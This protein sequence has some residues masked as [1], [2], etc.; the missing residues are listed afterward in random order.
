MFPF[1]YL[2][3]YDARMWGKMSFFRLGELV[4]RGWGAFTRQ[5]VP[6]GG[7]VAR[8]VIVEHHLDGQIKGIGRCVLDLK[9]RRKRK[10]GEADLSI[11]CNGF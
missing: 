3:V 9:M 6:N 7:R 1:Q 10:Y 5:R 11:L 4:V 2:Y 8:R